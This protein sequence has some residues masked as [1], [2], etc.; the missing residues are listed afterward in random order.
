MSNQPEHT[1]LF[2]KVIRNKQFNFQPLEFGNISG[3]HVDVKDEEGTRWEFRMFPS[4]EG[5]WKIE[6][7]KL[8]S[9]ITDAKAELEE[10]VK[11]HE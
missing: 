1:N 2:N 3:Y 6:G 11:E 4:D 5:S 10:A 7:Q 8:P 9:W